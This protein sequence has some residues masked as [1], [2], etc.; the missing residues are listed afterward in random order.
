MS[1]LAEGSETIAEAFGNVLLPT[2]IDEDGPE[3]FVEALGIGRGL[4]EEKATRIVVHA[5]VPE[6]EAF[7]SRNS[8]GSIASAR[9]G[10]HARKPRKG[11]GCRKTRPGAR[12]S[13]GDRWRTTWG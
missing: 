4:E 12:S 5:S 1:V 7:L 13:S 2:A 8:Q 6:C 11:A 9:P 10:S 3:S